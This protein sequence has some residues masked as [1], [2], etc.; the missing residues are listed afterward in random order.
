[1]TGKACNYAAKKIRFLRERY[2]EVNEKIVNLKFCTPEYVGPLLQPDW[3]V[4]GGFYG[5]A[6]L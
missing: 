3:K 6:Y 4:P 2:L 5:F 1:M